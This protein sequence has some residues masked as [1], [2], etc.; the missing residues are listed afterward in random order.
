[1]AVRCGED[2]E[3]ERKE[4]LTL[5]DSSAWAE[6]GFCSICGSHIFYRIKETD[7]HEIPVGLFDD[8]SPFKFKLQVFIDSKPFFYSFQNRTKEMTK[9]QVIKHFADNKNT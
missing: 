4:N 2:I 5:Y 7:A 6:R 8:Q 3:F 1:M 9:A